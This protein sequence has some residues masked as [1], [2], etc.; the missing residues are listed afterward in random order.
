MRLLVQ[1]VKR[2]HVDVDG[3]TVGAIDHGLLLFLGIGQDDTEEDIRWLSHKV[4]GLRIFSDE[5]GKMNLSVKDIDG[6]VLLVSQFTLH[7]SV[8]KGFR[9]SF[10]HAAHPDMAIPLYETFKKALQVQLGSNKIA[11]GVFGAMM[12]VHLVNDG[13]VTIWMDSKSREG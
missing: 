11:E 4:C 12:D 8:K 2:A 1:R 10:V 3:E 7:A 5:E 9:P 6:A 13:P